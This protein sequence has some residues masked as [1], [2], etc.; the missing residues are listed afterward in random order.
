MLSAFVPEHV[1][2]QSVF[3]S[4]K[5]YWSELNMINFLQFDKE[6]SIPWS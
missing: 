3:Q 4:M 1:N 5:K 6:D 2:V